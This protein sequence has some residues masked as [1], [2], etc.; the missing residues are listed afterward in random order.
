MTIMALVGAHPEVVARRAGAVVLV[1]TTA[2][3]PRHIPPAVV[4]AAIVRSGLATRATRGP[5]GPFVVRFT[6]G[7]RPVWA[8]LEA[9]AALYAATPPATRAALVRSIRFM[10]LRA[11]LARCPVPVV[12]VVGARDR[13]TPTSLGADIVARV[14]DGELIVL[15]NAGHTLPF[16]EPDVLSEIIMAAAPIPAAL[17]EGGRYGR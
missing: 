1:S 12:V 14:P 13:L 10:D 4:E 9:S 6:A 2:A 8:H 7:R 3:R 11:G 17:S 5:L 16:E 15:P